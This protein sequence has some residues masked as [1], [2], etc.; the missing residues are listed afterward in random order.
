MC[1]ENEKEVLGKHLLIEP[2][3]TWGNSLFGSTETGSRD[4]VVCNKHRQIKSHGI[5]W[6]FLNRKLEISS[7]TLIW[8]VMIHKITSTDGRKGRYVCA[9]FLHICWVIPDPQSPAPSWAKSIFRCRK[10]HAR[11]L[12]APN[13]WY[14]KNAEDREAKKMMR[15][16]C[17]VAPAGDLACHRCSFSLVLLHRTA[18]RHP[19]GLLI[20]LYRG[21]LHVSYNG[22]TPFTRP[23]HKIIPA[24]YQR[25][26]CNYQ[27]WIWPKLLSRC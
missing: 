14:K 22:L 3:C 25:F 1:A 15:P 8:S 5:W 7:A 11:I 20:S 9:L 13:I 18:Y 19:L 27:P 4:G 6:W 12:L 16:T 17:H 2:D 21:G 10:S 24:C 26:L 23:G